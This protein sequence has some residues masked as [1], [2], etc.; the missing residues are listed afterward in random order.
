M[1]NYF[2]TGTIPQEKKSHATVLTATCSEMCGPCTQHSVGPTA[3]PDLL[4]KQQR[5]GEAVLCLETQTLAN[6]SAVR[7][8]IPTIYR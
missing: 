2:I 3:G 7:E 6:Q 5:S 4:Q 8:S 1:Q